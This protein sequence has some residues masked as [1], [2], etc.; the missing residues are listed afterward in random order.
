VAERLGLSVPEAAA[1]ALTVSTQNVAGAVRELTIA[2]GVDPR[3]LTLV[4]GGGASGLN[5]V[6]IARALGCRRVLLPR[7]AGALSAAGGLFA[8][9]VSEFSVVRFAETRD[10]DLAGVNAALADV[11]AQAEA[12][13]AGL[14]DHGVREQR[15]E[16]AVE[17]RYR[18]QVWELDVPLAGP[19]LRGPDD[20][21]ALER[22]F[23]ELHER[24]FAIHEPGQYLEC[25]VWKARAS[26]TLDA[27]S[28]ERPA[29]DPV[30]VDAEVPTPAWF[31]AGGRQAT[32]RIDG[33]RLA[34]GAVVT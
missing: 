34:A 19:E 31:D 11:R 26:A 17:A 14:G 29:A 33:S 15:I 9:L 4:A 21:A 10:P 32:A 23:H 13:L 12:F 5:V 2:R 7:T 28:L 1:A 27:P 25:L 3:R 30:P 22:T 16:Y 18:Q 6:A 24:T 20:V 8:D